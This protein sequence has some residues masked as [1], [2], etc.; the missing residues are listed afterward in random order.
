MSPDS[1]SIWIITG[2]RGAGKTRFCQKVVLAARERGLTV[3]GVISPAVLTKGIKTG[4]NVQD[5][6]TGETRLL[7]SARE[8]IP[9]AVTPHWKFNDAALAW[10][11]E[12]LRQG[13]PCDLL[14]VDEL[15]PLEL[16]HS[17]GWIEGIEALDGGKYRAAIAVV[18]SEL[19][20]RALQLWSHAAVLPIAKSESESEQLVHLNAILSS[21]SE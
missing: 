20:P 8:E 16:E 6:A 19:V 12:I 1:G 7:A 9:D 3:G 14:I 15:G 4:I 10:G 2:E 21:I 11:S 18:R 17:Q 13:T 5:L